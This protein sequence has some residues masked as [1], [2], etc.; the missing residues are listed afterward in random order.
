MWVK[1]CPA[2]KR[3]PV[4][5]PKQIITVDSVR[6]VPS[7]YPET[8][9]GCFGSLCQVVEFRGIAPLQLH[10]SS[11]SEKFDLVLT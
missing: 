8:G 7:F 1:D 9:E 5:Q 3:G 4:V 2:P 10:E 11:F 6:D